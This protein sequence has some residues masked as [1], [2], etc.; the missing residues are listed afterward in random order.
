MPSAVNAVP[1]TRAD[2]TAVDWAR[3][4]A[5]SHTVPVRQR[6]ARARRGTTYEFDI[7]GLRG[8]LVVT[9]LADGQPGEVFLKVSKQGSTLSGLCEVLSIMTSLALQHR[10]PLMEIVRRLLNQRFEP[11]G[12]TADPDVPAATSLADYLARRLAVD[13]LTEDERVRLG[14]PR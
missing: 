9:E 13:Y 2:N 3:R 14:L 8:H 12:L 11:S 10:V 7:A 6:P 5:K 4:M 1:P